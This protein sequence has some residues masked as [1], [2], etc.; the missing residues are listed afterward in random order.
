[1]EFDLIR[2]MFPDYLEEGELINQEDRVTLYLRSRRTSALCPS[3]KKPSVERTTYFT[4]RMQDLGVIEK[5]LFLVIRLAKYRCENPACDVKV[6]C[7]QI[8]DFANPK[9]RRTNR[10]NQMMTAFAMTQSAESTARKLEE[11]HIIVSGDTLLRLS[12]KWNFSVKPDMVHAVSID[13]FALK[14]S[15]DT[16]R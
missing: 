2:D 15:N 6:F 7:E 3:C 16:E 12:R 14:K 10:L 5:P 13:D 9:A 4:R 1:M 11:I 8:E